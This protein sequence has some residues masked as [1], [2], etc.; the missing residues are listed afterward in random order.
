MGKTRNFDV[1]N[2]RIRFKCPSC[3]ARR[4]SALPSNLRRKNIRCHK[5]GEIIRCMFNRRSRPRHTHLGKVEMITKDNKNL[6]VNL[7]D[8]SA[9]GIGIEMPLGSL[10]SRKIAIGH[11]VRFKCRWN[12]QLLDAGYFTVTTIKDQRVGLKKV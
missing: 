10:R 9:E 1:V 7:R 11:Q 6:D 12:S 3:G 2:N 8:I 4:N 5:C